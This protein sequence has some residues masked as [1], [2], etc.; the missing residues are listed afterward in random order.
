MQNEGFNKKRGK[1]TNKGIELMSKSTSCF[2]VGDVF[3]INEKNEKTGWIGAF[4]LVTE[5]KPWGIQ[6][7]V[8]YIETHDKSRRMFTRLKWDEI[9]YVGRSCLVPEDIFIRNLE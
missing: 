2:K 3:Q 5:I 6:G 1:I 7:F 8:H 9:D 4:V